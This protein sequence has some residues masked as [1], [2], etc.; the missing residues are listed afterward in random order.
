VS[1]CPWA[2]R[3][4]VL[5]RHI[6]DGASWWAEITRANEAPTPPDPVRMLRLAAATT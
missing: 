5:L 2:I 6:E 4:G 1:I 3:E